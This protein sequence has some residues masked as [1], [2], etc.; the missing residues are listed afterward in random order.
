MLGGAKDIGQPLKQLLYF[1]EDQIHFPTLMQTREWQLP[2]LLQGSIFPQ[3]HAT[4]RSQHNTRVRF[5]TNAFN[6]SSRRI[7]ALLWPWQL[8]VL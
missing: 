4:S 5:L 1:A 7:S 2:G 3:P 8:V 6:S